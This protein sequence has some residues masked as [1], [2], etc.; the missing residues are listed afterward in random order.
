MF[1][2]GLF[3]DKSVFITGGGSGIGYVMAKHFLELGA[4]VTIASRKKDRIEKASSEL[5]A[6]GNCYGATLDIREED[7][8]ARV[9]GEI[10]TQFGNLDILIN[11]AG[12]QFP[13]AAEN[14]SPNGWRAVINNNL[15]GTFLVTQ[16]MA[17]EFF[18]P[19]NRATSSIS[20]PK[21]IVD[22]RGWRTLVPHVQE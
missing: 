10:K 21:F 11:N 2:A 18:I 5:S 7:D 6:F 4:N 22:F 15:N 19:Q 13:S 16:I 14:I 17:K 3:K 12:G 20:L 1:Q 9:A 8:I